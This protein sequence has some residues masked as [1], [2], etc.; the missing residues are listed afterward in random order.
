MDQIYL[1]KLTRVNK[2]II[3]A[4]IALFLIN[5]VSSQFMQLSLVPFLGMS[6]QGIMSGKIFQLLSYPFLG[7]GL[8]EVVLNCLMLWLMGSEFELNWGTRRY[9][10]FLSSVV[11]GAAVLMLLIAGVSGSSA[12]QA[13]SLTGLSGMVT[14]LCVAYAF[15]YPDRIFSFM[16][17]IPVKAKIFCL[18]LA[19]ISFYQGFFT[20]YGAGA[21]S[22]LGAMGMGFLYMWLTTKNSKRKISK[23]G[24]SLDYWSK[25]KK[26]KANLSIVRDDGDGKSKNDGPKYWH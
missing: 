23:D 19:A 6:F 10:V 17:I 4:T 22:Q 5:T 3:I 1:P 7:T 20:T 21:W 26:S 24:Q 9:I 13:F 15:L 8:F 16:M 2:I 14:S 12:L 18:I 11:L 25:R